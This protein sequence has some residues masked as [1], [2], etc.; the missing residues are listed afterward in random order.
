MDPLCVV[1][2]WF[3]SVHFGQKL[4][5]GYGITHL[6]PGCCGLVVLRTPCTFPNSVKQTVLESSSTNSIFEFL[7]QSSKQVLAFVELDC[8]QGA[9]PR[10]CGKG[11]DSVLCPQERAGH[12]THGCPAW[13]LRGLL[14]P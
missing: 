6:L 11:S 5:G 1:P 3:Y 8:E 7:L 4:K 14:V 10:V 13:E 2:S 12:R 9:D